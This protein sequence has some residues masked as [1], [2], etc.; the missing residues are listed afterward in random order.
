MNYKYTKKIEDMTSKEIKQRIS[1]TMKI[2]FTDSINP[3]PYLGIVDETLLYEYNELVARCPMTG[4]LDLY[5]LS[6]QYR[7]DKLIP[8]LKSLKQYFLKWDPI[9]ISH[10]H[11]AAKI[12]S[13]FKKVIQPKHLA[14]ILKVAIR[15]GIK[16][17]V[18]I[19][20]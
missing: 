16:T 18:F 12:F 8:E 15:G 17:E 13:D 14:I 2:D 19:E 6:I 20:S 11:L 5:Q 3:I 10:E 4:I 7:P 9:P 1:E